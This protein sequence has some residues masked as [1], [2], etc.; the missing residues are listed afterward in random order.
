MESVLH[1]LPSV[2]SGDTSGISKAVNWKGGG[3]FVYCELAKCNQHFVDAVMAATDE[4][5]LKEILERV[6]NT[7]YISVKVN[8]SDIRDAAA[9]FDALSMEDKRKFIIELLDKNMLYV[10][11]C[12]LDDAEYAISAAD[13]A[14]NRTF[15]QLEETR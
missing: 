3:S 9:D 12:D 14:F 11:L 13:K 6:L 4:A 15:Y 7:G 5:Q 1:R 8:P 2:I 10:N